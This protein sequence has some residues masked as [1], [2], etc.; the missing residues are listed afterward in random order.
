MGDGYFPPAAPAELSA[1]P[2]RVPVRI[3]SGI[4]YTQLYR[5][6]ADNLRGFLTGSA[7]TSG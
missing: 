2:E 5:Q 6:S 3:R 7:P 1:F 4:S